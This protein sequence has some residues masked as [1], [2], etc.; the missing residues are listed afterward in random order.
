MA[1]TSRR[2]FLLGRAPRPARPLARIAAGCLAEEGIVCQSCRDA[3]LPRAVRFLP[4][5]RGVARPVIDAPRCTG[6]GDCT[7]VCPGRAITLE[8]AA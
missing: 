2:D 7:G 6:C 4:F 8:T 3:C 1:T 5:G